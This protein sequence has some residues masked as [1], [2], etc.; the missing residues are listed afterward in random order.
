MQWK[1][2]IASTAGAAL[3]GAL[4]AGCS[5]DGA[6]GPGGASGGSS[7]VGEALGGS[8]PWW[9]EDVF[10]EVFVRS[11]RD[12]DGDGNGDLAGLIEELD[13]LNDGD[14]ATDDDL[15][16]TGLWLMPIT[17]SPSYHG[18]DA[19]DFVTVE[20]DYGTNEDFRALVAAAHEA[21]SP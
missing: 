9:N 8:V 14:P 4:L 12:S 17:A 19:T 13:H 15:G 5:D 18:Y 16:V 10:Y 7:A 21:G 2:V 11:F 20:P 1:R 6:D 3:V